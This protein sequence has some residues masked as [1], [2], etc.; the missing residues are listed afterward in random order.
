MCLE[1]NL[2]SLFGG[3]KLKAGNNLVSNC[4]ADF[5][6]IVLYLVE[7]VSVFLLNSTQNILK[8]IYNSPSGDVLLISDDDLATPKE[9]SE[10]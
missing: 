7:Y 10:C 1:K 9:P 5:I 6:F 2:L 4:L 8:D 3:M